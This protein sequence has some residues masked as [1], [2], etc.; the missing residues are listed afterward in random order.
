MTKDHQECKLGK[1]HRYQTRNKAIP[2]LPNVTSNMYRSS[3]LFK[4]VALYSKLDEKI[5]NLPNLTI[6]VKHCKEM[7]LSKH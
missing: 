3:F 4:S 6:F 2:N 5:K 1:E 7:Y